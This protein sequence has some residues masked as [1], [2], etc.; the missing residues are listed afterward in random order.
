MSPLLGGARPATNSSQPPCGPDPGLGQHVGHHQNVR[1]VLLQPE[2]HL[3][4][5][6]ELLK[7]IETTNCIKR[8][9]ED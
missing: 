3:S 8:D 5:L 2:L 9:N 4:V 6:V 7:Q 1:I